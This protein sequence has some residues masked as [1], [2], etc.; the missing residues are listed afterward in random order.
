MSLL[1][2]AAVRAA[3]IGDDGLHKAAWMRETFK[4]L[5]EDLQEANAEGKKLAVLVEQQ[6]C[7]YWKKMHENV[8]S[9]PFVFQYL[10]DHFF[11]V[12]IN[13]FGNVEV[14]DFDGQTLEKREM[15]SKWG[16]LF[17]PTIMFFPEELDEFN[18]ANVVMIVSMP[19]AFGKETSKNLL[20][21][22]E[23]KVYEITGSS[24]QKYH[25]DK[26]NARQS[27]QSD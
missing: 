2:S 16:V 21:W 3:D 4:D 18:Y 26:Y 13:M 7:L 1:V 23:E 8:F 19:G 5:S 11:V 22:M 27:A 14:T 12:Q 24:F 17:T 10:I 25:A 9:D 6:N 15:V 20:S